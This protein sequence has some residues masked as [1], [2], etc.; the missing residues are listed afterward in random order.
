LPG[1]FDPSHHTGNFADTHYGMPCNVY[2]AFTPLLIQKN[3]GSCLFK[4]TRADI[5]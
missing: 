5:A 3:G 4:Q 1:W 2:F